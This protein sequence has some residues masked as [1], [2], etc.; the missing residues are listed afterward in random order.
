MSEDEF[1]QARRACSRP[2]DI[3]ALCLE[4]PATM[5]HNGLKLMPI[6]L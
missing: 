4:H 2:H 3:A 6:I 1:L 5:Q